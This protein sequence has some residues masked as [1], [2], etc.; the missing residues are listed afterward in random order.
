MNG[1]TFSVSEIP[2]V[3]SVLMQTVYKGGVNNGVGHTGIV[4][5]VEY[6]EN[7][8]TYTIT[9]FEQNFQP[10]PSIGTNVI[11]EYDLDSSLLNYS[12]DSGEIDP[13]MKFDEDGKQISMGII[14]S[15]RKVEFNPSNTDDYVFVTTDTTKEYGKGSFE[16]E[17]FYQI[18]SILTD[19]GFLKYNQNISNQEQNAALQ[20]FLGDVTKQGDWEAKIDAM[21]VISNIYNLTVGK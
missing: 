6:N 2:T 11:S 18:K 7:T 9:L 4:T 3:G 10:S 16:K 1:N 14:T 21:A 17:T 8:G 19:S 20:S 5:N 12:F 13:S 15:N